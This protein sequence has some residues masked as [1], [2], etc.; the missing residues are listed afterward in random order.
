MNPPH[1][2]AGVASA[3][4]GGNTGHSPNLRPWRVGESGNPAGRSLSL[5]NLAWEARRATDGGRELIRLQLAIARG[6][7]IPVPGRARGQRPTIDQRQQAIAW[8]A[9]R[10]FG[11]AKEIIELAGEASPPQRLELLRRL[12][13]PE[14]EQLRGLLAKALAPESASSAT[15]PEAA[16]GPA[17]EPPAAERPPIEPP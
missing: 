2:D 10:A 17:P 9:D 8:L 14:R 4:T 11:K 1:D 12:S 13:D 7:E 3:T 16:L 5:V 15:E 6:E